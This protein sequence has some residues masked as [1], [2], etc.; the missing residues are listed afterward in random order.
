MSAKHN[1][2]CP[3]HAAVTL[4]VTVVRAGNSVRVVTLTF[5][6]SF[7][8]LRNLQSPRSSGSL[9]LSVTLISPSTTRILDT[10]S[11]PPD[12]KHKFLSGSLQPLLLSPLDFWTHD[13]STID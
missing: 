3:H 12:G 1:P 9:K 5:A 6:Y 8:G 7:S 13:L 11:R 4:P 2:L 10:D